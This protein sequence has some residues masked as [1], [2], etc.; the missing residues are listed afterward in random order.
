MVAT[1]ADQGTNADLSFTINNANNVPFVIDDQGNIRTSGPLDRET[2]P[3][4]NFLVTVLDSKF[5]KSILC[6]ILCRLH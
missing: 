3:Q 2:V 5:I 4:Y 6:F 1:D